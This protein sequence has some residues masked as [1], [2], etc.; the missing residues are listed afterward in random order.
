MTIPQSS[1]G[2]KLPRLTRIVATVGPASNSPEMIEKLIKAGVEVFRLNFSHGSHEFHQATF[3]TIR[4]VAGRLGE[5]TVILQDVSGPKLR[6]NEF[7]GGEAQIQNGALFTLIC[8]LKLGDNKQV[9]FI[10]SGWFKSIKSGD[11][12]ALGDGQIIL[13]VEKKTE[14]SLECIVKAGGLV[15]SKW[16]LNFPDSNLELGAITEKDRLD[17]AFGLKLGVDAIALSF[18]QGPEDLKVV[19]GLMKNSLHRPMLISKIERH[20]AVDKIEA[21]LKESDGLM[22]ARGDLGIDLPM[23]QVPTVQ[24][25]LIRLCREKGK[26]VI[27]ATQMLESMTSSPRPTRA[28]VTDVANAVYDGTDAV[29]LSGETA[30]GADPV[31]VVETMS[32][33]LLEAESHLE[34]TAPKGL[35]ET[36]E[37]AVVDAVGVLVRDLDAR[38]ILVPYTSGVTAARISRLRLGKPIVAGARS[39]EAARRMH[40]F[41]GVYPIQGKSETS[42]LVNTSSALDYASAKGWI[43]KGDITV[44]T[45]GFPLGR[46]GVTNFVRAILFGE[47]L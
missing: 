16:G 7:E 18:V 27:T 35:D 5:P 22:V 26:A 28:E 13:Q 8:D 47:E 12:V 17:I 40:L 29:M 21:I 44:A 38:A 36:I 3:E 1:N 2:R 10:D 14:N 24:K 37:S 9:G 6:I 45:G 43:I 20:Q 31:L 34:L 25:R 15:R 23:E 33:I 42:W 30:V 11:R 41:S 46:V 39:A 4:R 19:K 32:Q